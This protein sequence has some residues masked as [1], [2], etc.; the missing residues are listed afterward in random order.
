MVSGLA[1]VWMVLVVAQDPGFVTGT[2]LAGRFAIWVPPGAVTGAPAVV[3]FFTGTRRR[4]RLSVSVAAGLRFGCL[5]IGR[6]GGLSMAPAQAL[7]AGCWEP[8][9]LPSLAMERLLR[10][11]LKADSRLCARAILSRRAA[12]GAPRWKSSGPARAPLGRVWGVVLG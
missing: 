6:A 9:G 8:Y 4:L 5:R 3:G 7:A 2:G 11:A 12:R 1:G 10:L